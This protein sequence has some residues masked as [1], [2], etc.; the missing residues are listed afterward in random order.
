[1]PMHILVV[2]PAKRH[3]ELITNLAPEGPRLRKFEVM[4]IGRALL[5]DE[6]RLST[7]KEKVGFVAF[8]SFLWAHQRRGRILRRAAVHR[9]A[10]RKCRLRC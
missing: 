1:M 8:S 4:G 3:G 7:D 6:T 9:L 2:C 10:A 5:A